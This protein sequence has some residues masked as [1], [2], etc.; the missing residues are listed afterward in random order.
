MERVLDGAVSA[1]RTPT[2][3]RRGS[4]SQAGAPGAAAIAA[5]ATEGDALRVAVHRDGDAFIGLQSV[6]GHITRSAAQAA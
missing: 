2:R 3:S 6:G 5:F 4:T 1:T